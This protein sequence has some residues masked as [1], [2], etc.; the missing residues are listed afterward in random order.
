MGVSASNVMYAIA[1]QSILQELRRRGEITHVQLTDMETAATSAAARRL[2]E[3]LIDTKR[4]A[5]PEVAAA[6]VFARLGI[7]SRLERGGA[8][9]WESACR[10]SL[11]RSWCRR[12]GER[13][14]CRSA[15]SGG[16]RPR[17]G[18]G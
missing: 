14:G 2:G 1:V 6:T 3:H 5:T 11:K 8:S 18:H 7:S 9:A 10:L 13:T 17:M 16:L 15:R 12:G 4:V